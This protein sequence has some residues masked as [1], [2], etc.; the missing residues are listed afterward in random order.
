LSIKTYPLILDDPEAVIEP[1]KITVQYEL[2]KPHDGGQTD[3]M[4]RAEFEVLFGGAA[5][6]GKS[7]CLVLDALGLQYAHEEFGMPAYQHP[8]YRAVLFRRTSVRLQ[9]LIDQAKSLYYPLGGKFVL[10]RK[11]EPGSCFTFNSGAKIF[12]CHLEEP[13]DVENHQG[14]EYQFAGYDELTQF[15]LGQYIYMFSRLRG[16]VENNGVSLPKRLRATTNPI[17]PGLTWVKRRFLKMGQKTLIPGRTYFF[18][19][20]PDVDKPEDNPMG[21]RVS[22]SHP[23]FAF[24]KSR[25]FIPGF[26]HENQ[27]LMESDPGYASNIM[28][29]G[30]KMEGALLHNDWEAFGGDFFSMI[31]K[32]TM[33]VKPFDIPADWELIGAIDPGWGNPCAF[34]LWARDK[35]GRAFLLFTYYVRRSDPASHA[36]RIKKLIDKFPYIG[37]RSPSMIVSGVD[38]FVK[39]DLHAAQPSELTFSDI[40][41]DNGLYLER[42]NTDRQMGWWVVKQYMISKMFFW[43]DGLNNAWYDELSAIST[44]ENNIEEIKGQG[45][46]PEVA[47]HAAD[48]TR[49]ALM[50]LPFPFTKLQ[51]FLPRDFEYK[52]K[53]KKKQKVS[54]MSY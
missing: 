24:S 39:K 12:L 8:D 3:Y 19:A 46:D 35:Q 54:V 21:L 17:G 43:F 13:S 37:G 30:K 27:T 16:T 50:A 42:A 44:D 48:A 25:T 1:T 29:L 51:K 49:Y 28:Q 6:P 23:Q 2:I 10:Q 38:A 14:A 11:G 9:N 18:I 41:Q 33:C 40:F 7:W 4:S 32:H 45:R 26:L 15:T 47:A 52:S 34:G 53:K 5:G 31:D 36:Q 22:P 20:D